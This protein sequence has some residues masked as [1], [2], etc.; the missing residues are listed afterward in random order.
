MSSF[1]SGGNDIN[2]SNKSQY[3]PSAASDAV[4]QELQEQVKRLQD[5]GV[6]GDL[7][8]ILQHLATMQQQNQQLI[9]ENELKTQ[10]I[11][12]LETKTVENMN[13]VM[14][15]SLVPWLN[16]MPGLDPKEVENVVKGL[17][18]LIGL[19]KEESGVWRVMACASSVHQ[20][21]VNKLEELQREANELRERVSGGKFGSEDSRMIDDG[22]GKKR[23]HDVIS[24]E[25]ARTKPMVWDDIELMLKHEN[26]LVPRER[27]A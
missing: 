1:Q 14:D 12:K 5:A 4:I 11:G 10:R 8:A 20:Q 22:A 3:K 21:N 24:N 2:D 17:R 7:G 23:K 19:A 25:P 15:E 26:G 9:Q 6:K 16:S 13:K 27:A 18:E